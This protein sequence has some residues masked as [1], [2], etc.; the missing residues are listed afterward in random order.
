VKIYIVDAF[1]EKA[2]TGNPAAI[3]PLD[4]WL[5]ESVMQN[6]AMENNQAET[7]YFVNEGDHYRIRWFTPNVEVDLCGH[8]TLASAYVL[9]Q[10]LGHKSNEIRFTT[11]R[12]GMLK[13]TRDD[14]LL[15]LDFP[16]D[17]IS[18]LPATPEILASFQSRPT[19]IFK[20]KSDI[21]CVFENEKI[22][23]NIQ[24]DYFAIGRL[25]CRGV[26]AT[27]KG[28]DVDFVSRWFGPQTGIN[29]DPVTGSAHTT[30]TPYWSQKLKKKELQASQ[31]S[32]RG[33]KLKCVNNDA[34][35]LISGK[36]RTYLIGEI[37]L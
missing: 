25:P 29:E 15:T 26:I 27:A 14:D 3:C 33:G 24:P 11:Q 17:T 7:A 16:A 6:I 36:A 28:D 19:E 2:F 4:S 30:L 31:L 23:R 13:V 20:G 37:H 9:Y 10:Y 35:V 18:P 5:P 34:R 1:A 8:A 32:P 22:I 12:S 21:M